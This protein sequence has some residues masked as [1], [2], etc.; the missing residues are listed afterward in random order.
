MQLE[1]QPQ[2]LTAQAPA[3]GRQG[4]QLAELAGEVR[5][6]AGAA[7]ATGSPEAAAALEGFTRTWSASVLLLADI[8]AA[9]GAATGSAA[10]AY[11]AT[12]AGVIPAGR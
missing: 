4:G 6:L 3:I 1:V 9:L 11:T 7:G 8:V 2:A 10:T 12:D 5:G